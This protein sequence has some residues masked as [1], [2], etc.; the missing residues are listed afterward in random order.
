MSAAL[1]NLIQ[2]RPNTAG[3]FNAYLLNVDFEAAGGEQWS[4]VGGG[5]SVAEAIAVAQDALPAGP[6]WSLSAWN[7]LYGE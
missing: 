7:H 3:R 4:A 1:D 2:L 6:A 5:E